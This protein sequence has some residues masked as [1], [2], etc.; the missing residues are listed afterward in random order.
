MCLGMCELI[1]SKWADSSLYVTKLF[2][3]VRVEEGTVTT[4]IT[5]PVLWRRDIR[6]ARRDYVVDMHE[7]VHR[8]VTSLYFPVKDKRWLR[9]SIK[10]VEGRAREVGYTIEQTTPPRWWMPGL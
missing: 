2:G 6:W 3:L 1:R 10:N 8:W 5:L 9:T 7:P 4:W